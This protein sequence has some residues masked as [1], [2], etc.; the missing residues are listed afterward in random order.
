VKYKALIVQITLI[1]LSLL[2][3]VPFVH[4][5]TDISGD[6]AKNCTYAGADSGT[7][8]TCA[9]GG[10]VWTAVGCIQTSSPQSLFA[11]VFRVGTG[12]AGGIAFLLILFGGF[13]ILTSAG[14]PEQLN[15]GQELVSS[16]VAGL[17]LII[18]SIF[19]LKLIGYDILRIPGFAP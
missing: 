1:V 9:Q 19:L 16:A 8:E 14:N 4:A 10:G 13:Q 3:I 15:G 6:L 2:M 17:L 5:Q 11:A 12:I 18:F 7:C